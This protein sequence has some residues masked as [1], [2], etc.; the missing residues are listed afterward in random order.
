MMTNR[1]V[2]RLRTVMTKLTVAFFLTPNNIRSVMIATMMT[3][4]MDRS[5]SHGKL[6]PASQS[7]TDTSTIL[8]KLTT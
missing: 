1:M 2:M 8:K 6:Y 3:D 7:G 5:N 4:R